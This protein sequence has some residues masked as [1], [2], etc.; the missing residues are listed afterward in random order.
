MSKIT[1][2]QIGKL[3]MSFIVGDNEREKRYW[4]KKERE[5]RQSKDA[6]FIRDR[7]ARGVAQ[8]IYNDQK[9]IYTTL[10]Q[11]M[12]EK[13]DKLI[14]LILQDLG[15]DEDINKPLSYTEMKEVMNYY[16]DKGISQLKNSMPKDILEDYGIKENTPYSKFFK[17]LIE[18][19]AEFLV[20]APKDRYNL[21]APY[22]K[23]KDEEFCVELA[24]RM[25][26][27][28]LFITSKN[29]EK[30]NRLYNIYKNETENNKTDSLGV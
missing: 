22:K 29:R 13:S 4:D 24:K 26:A 20:F 9:E 23:V 8:E 19:R 15:L 10:M 21:S 6:S 2:R 28:G 27:N 17:D 11:K 16:Q 14:D 12:Y 30:F 25:N 18:I 1:Q 7:I 3:R 5:T